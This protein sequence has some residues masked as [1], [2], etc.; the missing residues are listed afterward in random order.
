[1]GQPR[2][3]GPALLI[4][5]IIAR[6]PAA[7]S[8]AEAALAAKFG[9]VADRSDPVP[10]DFTGYYRRELGPSPVRRWVGF[11]DTVDPSRLAGI[12]LQTNALEQDMA[13]EHG[14]RT[15]N[16]DPGILSLHNLVLASTK[17]HDHRVCLHDGIYAE[18]TLRYR[19][20]RF[21]PLPWTYPDYRG[22]ACLAF[23]ARC[24]ERL[25]PRPAAP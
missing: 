4:C 17:D 6:D 13:D 19:S 22:P 21:E 15:A 11:R 16:L 9:P 25:T 3:G 24:R 5:G 7:V 18:L 20:G 2:P 14:H 23:L 10:F 8:R 1:M 12:K